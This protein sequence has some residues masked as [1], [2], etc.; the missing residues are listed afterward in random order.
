MPRNKLPLDPQAREAAETIANER[1]DIEDALRPAHAGEL[2]SIAGWHDDFLQV[3]RAQRRRAQAQE[4]K[5]TRREAKRRSSEPVPAPNPVLAPLVL[6]FGLVPAL[7]RLLARLWRTASRSRPHSSGVAAAGQRLPTPMRALPAPGARPQ[8]QPGPGVGGNAGA[9]A[10]PPRG[11]GREPAPRAGFSFAAPRRLWRT[12][13][14]WLALSSAGLAAAQVIVPDFVAAAASGAVSA[15]TSPDS[16]DRIDEAR[17]CAKRDRLLA[18]DGSIAGHLRARNCPENPHEPFRSAEVSLRDAEWLLPAFEAVEGEIDGSSAVLGISLPG[19]V[20]AG[21]SLIN[22]MAG[23]KSVVG[24]SSPLISSVE[25]ALGQTHSL[26]F[27]DKLS[28]MAQTVVYSAHRLT[29]H[30]ARVVFVAETLPCAWGERN[31]LAAFGPPIAGSLCPLIFGKSFISELDDAER[32]VWAAAIKLGIRIT[33]PIADEKVLAHARQINEAIRSR[34]ITKCADV[35][36]ASG[37][38]SKDAHDDMVGR[39]ARL[40]FPVAKGSV[41]LDPDLLLADRLPG[42]APAIRDA[43]ELGEAVDNRL[44]L[45]PSVQRALNRNLRKALTHI[46]QDISPELCLRGCLR[47]D[48][49]ADVLVA[50]AEKG[51][52][53]LA[54]RGIFTTRD[55]LFS[56]PIYQGERDHP[57]RSPGSLAKA[58]AV[59]PVA[60][61]IGDGDKLCRKRFA[62][63]HDP[64]GQMGFDCSRPEHWITPFETYAESTN[65]AFAYALSRVDPHRLRDFLKASGFSIAD[66]VSDQELI[67]STTLGTNTVLTPELAMRNMAVMAFSEPGGIDLP[68]IY[69][70]RTPRA[71][72]SLA[73]LAISERTRARAMQWLTAPVDSPNGTLKML[74]PDLRALG[75]SS[76][77]AKSGTSD[78][79]AFEKAVRDRLALVAVRCGERELVAFALIGSPTID[80]H[81]GWVPSRDLAE[82]IGAAV[83]AALSSPADSSVEGRYPNV[84]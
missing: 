14:I 11:A 58:L 2:N 81:L 34:A 35:L 75:C 78:S 76:I 66:S 30:E 37:A 71:S 64:D 74:G 16:S 39:I 67:R 84:E 61:V 52:G 19:M 20:R 69:V 25:V 45:D 53:R 42:A 56:G 62:S 38:V 57:S 36:F 10:T 40:R 13:A 17:R 21:G 54:L 6:L 9:G 80:T 26:S 43:R 60:E 49:Q 22:R 33:S 29:T 59:L 1:L 27:G 79:L 50:I 44:Q 65:T 5:Q 73:Q 8:P 51:G 28:M 24:G 47:D 48:R 82:L 32:C 77:H 68:E 12:V 23:G 46:A 63:L 31:G 18:P 72:L 4:R 83:K 55:E 70:A 3:N 15:L 7:F 41:P